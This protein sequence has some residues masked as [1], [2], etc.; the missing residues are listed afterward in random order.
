M[1][2]NRRKFIR[3][4]INLIIKVEGE[5]ED[6]ECVTRDFSAGGAYMLSEK[7]FPE[8]EIV[9]MTFT[10]EGVERTFTVKAKI[11]WANPGGRVI[12]RGMGVEFVDMN[13]HDFQFLKDYVNSYIEEEDVKKKVASGE[14]SSE[15]KVQPKEKKEEV[16]EPEEIE[17]ID[18]DSEG[19]VLIADDSYGIRMKLVQM[20]KK[21]NYHV[22]GE[23][24]D[25]VQAVKMFTKFNPD[26][27]V[28]DVKMPNMDGLTALKE[29]KKIDSSARVILVSTLFVRTKEV[30][31]AT[32]VGATACLRVPFTERMLI[33]LLS[34]CV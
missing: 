21:N 4:H 16:P 28:M 11:A 33:K 3:K 18:P 13:E 29:I 27:V 24:L 30:E 26:F 34:D 10:L 8:Q 32:M 14:L 6:L 20:L 15:P 25:G 7:L 12:P 17:V 5:K 31:N 9:S 23:A 22:V 2:I 1:S 19:T